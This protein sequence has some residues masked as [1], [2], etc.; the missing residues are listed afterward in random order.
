MEK[1]R[2]AI[3]AIT[4][5]MQKPGI[6]ELG[7]ANL[8]KTHACILMTRNYKDINDIKKALKMFKQAGA[9]FNTIGCKKGLG[10]CKFAL[11]KVHNEFMPELI[12]LLPGK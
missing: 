3:K 4:E 12:K 10:L 7:R 11:A 2:D 6:S 9:L 8:L 5:Y 1:R